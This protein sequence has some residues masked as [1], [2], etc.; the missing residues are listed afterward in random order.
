MNW[1]VLIPAYQPDGGLN[2]LVETLLQNNMAVIV[3]DDGS[4]GCE[5]VFQE[6]EQLPCTVLHHAHN[7]GKGR[8]LKT[9]FGWM[10][11]HGFEGAVTADADG[12]HTA[13]DIRRVA[14]AMEAEPGKLIL[15]ARTVEQMP[16][17]SRVG[18]TMTRKLFALLYGV[19]I[20]DTQT[21]LRGVPLQGESDR[22]RQMLELDGERYE[23][24]M[25]MLVFSRQLFDGI[26]EIPIQTIYINNNESSHFRPIQDGMKIYAVL[27]R[28]FPKFLAASLAS[29]MLDYC[30]FA[31]LYYGLFHNAV[32][33]TVGARIVSA[34]CNY[35]MNKHMVFKSK[36]RS[37]TPLRYFALAVFVLAVNSGLMFL[38]VDWLHFPAMLVKVIVESVMYLV[39]FTVQ[40]KWAHGEKEVKATAEQK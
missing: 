4:I 5:M 1:G 40:N 29:F 30:L 31:L 16:G 17:R 39:S 36:S 26:R 10:Q 15:G 12:Q 9:G 22:A 32:L 7:Q 8:A 33:S 21:G 11:E 14:E 18:N 37:Y 35:L 13:E 23:Y 6:L 25:N 38:F 20:S 24:E 19:H 34:S 27:L 28:Q 2:A 3:V